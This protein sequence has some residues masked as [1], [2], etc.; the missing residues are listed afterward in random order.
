M[1]DTIVIQMKIIGIREL[2]HR[3]RQVLQV[4]SQGEKV[5]VSVRGKPAAAL[6][7]LTEDGLEAFVLRD[8]LEWLR[9]SESALDFWDNPK[10]EAWNDA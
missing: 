2:R 4:V 6:V 9:L 10:D 1:G 7:P 3:T 5:V 8:H